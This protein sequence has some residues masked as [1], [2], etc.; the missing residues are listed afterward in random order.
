MKITKSELK[1]RCIDNETAIATLESLLKEHGITRKQEPKLKQLDQSVFDGLDAKWRFAVMQ[2]N[3]YVIVCNQKPFL[4]FG[5]SSWDWNGHNIGIGGG[6][7][8]S[9]WQN[10]LIER[11]ELTGSDLCRAMLERGDKFVMC[12]VSD[13]DDIEAAD[14]EDDDFLAEAVTDFDDVD[15]LFDAASM[16][17]LYAVPINNQGEP[18]TASEVGL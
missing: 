15:G 12:G 4:A 18:L 6:Y 17:W 10:S 1:Q 5:G 9:D 7:D 16:R 11:K 8:T 13:G 14:I 3:G 2:S